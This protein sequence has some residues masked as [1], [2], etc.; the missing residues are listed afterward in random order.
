[1][2]FEIFQCFLHK[3]FDVNFVSFQIDKFY[4]FFCLVFWLTS[5]DCTLSEFRKSV[6]AYF[7]NWQDYMEI[8]N[9]RLG[10]FIGSLADLLNG[11][12]S[13]D[14]NV[15]VQSAKIVLERINNAPQSC[16]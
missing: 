6:L 15:F 3:A 5:S 14:N 9:K 1:M 4:K 12:E 11:L 7:K 16:Q 2:L 8:L 10:K 13:G